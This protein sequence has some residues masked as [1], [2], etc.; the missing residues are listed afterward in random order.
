MVRISVD[1][2]EEVAERLLRAAGE[3]QSSPE[4][5]LAQA[6]EDMLA[7]RAALEAAVAEGEVDLAAGRLVAHEDVMRE[8]EDWARSVRARRAPR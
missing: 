8:M 2:P 1:L 3:M 4:S 6:A 5:L 7:E